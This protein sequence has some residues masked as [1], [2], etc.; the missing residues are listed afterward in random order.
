MEQLAKEAKAVWRTGNYDSASAFFA[1][2]P[3]YEPVAKLFLDKDSTNDSDNS[4]AERNEIDTDESDEEE[5]SAKSY[6]SGPMRVSREA[7]IY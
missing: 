6:G 3:E 7:P 2:H 1:A 4:V 5:L